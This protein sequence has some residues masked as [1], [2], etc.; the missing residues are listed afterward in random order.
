MLCNQYD[1]LTGQYVVSFLADVDPMNPTR[2][3]VPAFCTFEPLPERA[4]RTWPFWRDEKW[5]MLPD[6]RGVR[7]YRTESGAAAEITV[8]GVTPDDAGLTE[9]PRP[10]DAHVWREGAWVVDEKIVADRA[11]ESAMNDFF[12]RLEKARQQNR[13]KADARMTGRLSDL[14]E[15]TFDAWADYQ[16]SLVNVVESLTF[17]AQFAWPAEPDQAAILAKVEAERAAKAKREAEEAAQRAAA[18]K[19]AEEDRAE[20]EAEM[21]RRSEEAATTDAA[22]EPEQQKASDTS[23]KK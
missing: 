3:L 9:D 15:T 12:A 4:P 5:D 1:S 21:Q 13:G 16:V 6:Y 11:R 17:P 7:L 14:E 23:V 20:A 10:S 18:E 22:P 8:A 2:Y 19:Q